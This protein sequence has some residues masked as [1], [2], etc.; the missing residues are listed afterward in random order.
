MPFEVI[1]RDVGR[2]QQTWS[3]RFR[4]KPDDVALYREVKAKKALGSRG[5]D[6]EWNEEETGGLITV[7]A[8]H[9]VGVFEL[10]EVPA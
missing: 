7:G 6:F 8:F 9:Q 10:R 3:K 4:E 2:G 5:V 1:F